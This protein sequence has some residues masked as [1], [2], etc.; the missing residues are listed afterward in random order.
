MLIVLVQSCTYEKNHKYQKHV[1]V[2]C[3][4]LFLKQN[5]RLKS[6]VL[7]MYTNANITNIIS[8]YM[9]LS[10]NRYVVLQKI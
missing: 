2:D 4:N 5:S 8:L 7:C 6:K 10:L 3:M 9:G 1:H